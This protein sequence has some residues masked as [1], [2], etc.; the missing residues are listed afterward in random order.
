M[1]FNIY[2]TDPT[3]VAATGVAPD[4][5]SVTKLNNG[6][7]VVVWQ[8][9]DL[10]TD[11]IFMKVYGPS[12]AVVL[13]KTLVTPDL[14]N[15]AAGAAGSQSMPS[16]AARPNGGFVV[17]WQSDQTGGGDVCQ[18]VYQ[19]DGTHD[20]TLW[21]LQSG[22][23]ANQTVV[24]SS[25]TGY[26]AENA[27]TSP[28]VA[29]FSDGHWIVTM[30]SVDGTSNVD[31]VQ[32]IYSTSGPSFTPSTVIASDTPAISAVTPINFDAWVVVWRDQIT[33][34]LRQDVFVGAFPSA[35]NLVPSPDND[36]IAE[37]V[38]AVKPEVVPLGN[39]KYVV[40]WEAGGDVHQALFQYT[41]S[42]SG[43][44]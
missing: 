9:D 34:D 15:P 28:S 23:I 39:N 31:L 5:V 16:V 6:G 4:S 43:R 33:G 18:S 38:A 37:D 13:D 3:I 2:Q 32:Q 7:W 11:D 27:Q 44:G 40:I 10:G 26:V 24:A 21:Q 20:G 41:P 29:A 17:V 19:N 35:P 12:G 14:G 1:A 30:A 36:L 22:Y 8:S 42:R 25:T